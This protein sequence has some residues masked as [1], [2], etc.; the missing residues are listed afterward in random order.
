MK[1]GDF[2]VTSDLLGHGRAIRQN[3]SIS[4]MCGYI[5]A[6]ALEPASGE[7]SCIKCM[8]RKM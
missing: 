5:I 3:E 1:P 8:I 4:S 7:S 2:I 6:Q